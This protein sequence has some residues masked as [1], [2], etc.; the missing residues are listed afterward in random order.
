[1]GTGK[2]GSD[3]GMLQTQPIPALLGICHV[4]AERNVLRI[5]KGKRFKEDKRITE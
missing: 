3:S 4:S 5:Q 1:M 2:E